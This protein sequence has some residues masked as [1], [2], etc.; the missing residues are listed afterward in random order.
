VWFFT[1]YNNGYENEDIEISGLGF[2]RDKRIS[3]IFAGKLTW[4][5]SA[6]PRLACRIMF[7]FSSEAL[8]DGRH[9]FGF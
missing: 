7:S 9:R 6:P 5:A 1:A 3:H 4:R 2:Q 8:P